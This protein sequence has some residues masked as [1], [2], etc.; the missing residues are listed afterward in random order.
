MLVPLLDGLD[1]LGLER[2][3]K[4]IEK[5]N[6]FAEHYPKLV[7]CCRVKEFE[8][9]NIKL[10][11][12]RGAVCLQPLSDSQI[13]H[14]FQS[15]DRLDTWSAIQNNQ[16]LQNLLKTTQ[17]INPRL[18]RLEVHTEVFEKWQ[19]SLW[20]INH[21]LLRIPLFINFFTNVYDSENS[22]L[23]KADLLDMYIGH[24]LSSEK[25]SQDRR[26]ELEEYNWAYKTIELEPERE[27]T[28]SHL[29]WLARN[30][31]AS[32]NVDFFIHEIQP[33]WV[34]PFR[35]KTIY[36]LI[37]WIVSLLTASLFSY[38]ENHTKTVAID[39]FSLILMAFSYQTM[40]AFPSQM[41]IKI[42]ELTKPFIYFVIAFHLIIIVLNFKFSFL[43]HWSIGL[44]NTSFFIF[45]WGG[46]LQRLSLRI[47]LWQS[48]LPWNFA[49]FLNYCVERRLLLR[50]GGSYR[51]LHRELLDHF[52]Q[53]NH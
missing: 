13:K 44:F 8:T 46:H 22:I 12:L 29:H 18:L 24:R 27:I 48:G 52:A 33:G 23:N 49:R 25:R 11:T 1:E 38:L 51:F 31:Q 16:N 9:V 41:K 53:S 3:K 35:S 36:Y 5:L 50:V 42:A 4:C 47:F 37:Y 30:L 21:G 6:E 39:I 32:N 45:V 34:E 14:Y 43:Q 19:E 28:C 15:L 20:E 17:E 40:D 2:Q 26:C 7:V 10:R